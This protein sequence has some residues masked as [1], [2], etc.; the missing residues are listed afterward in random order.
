V[1]PTVTRETAEYVLGLDVIGQYL[2]ERAECD[3][4]YKVQSRTL[5]ADFMVW[6][7]AR[8]I[9]HPISDKRFKSD[10]AAKGILARRGSTGIFYQGVRI[11]LADEPTMVA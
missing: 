9:Q 7:T 10:L 3:P 1:E 4:S 6:S 8:G 11:A 2:E 5:Y